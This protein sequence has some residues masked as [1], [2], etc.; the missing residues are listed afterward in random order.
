MDALPA[1]E[2]NGEVVTSVNPGV[3]HLCGHDIHMAV[4]LTAARMMSDNKDRLKFNIRFLFQPSEEMFRGGAKGMVEAGCL[5]GVERVYGL[6]NDPQIDYGKISV[7]PGIMSSNGDQFKVTIEGKSA[8]ASAPHLGRDA[9]SEAVRLLNSFRSIITDNVDPNKAALISTCMLKVGEAPNILARNAEFQGSI[10]SFDKDVH[11]TLMEKFKN[12]LG[13]TCRRGFNVELDIRGY[14]AINN[15]RQATQDLIDVGHQL[16]GEEGVLTD[17]PPM[18]GS[19]DF[20]YFLE[21]RPGAFFFLGSG[22]HAKGICNPL[23]SNP[24]IANEKSIL[25]GALIYG[26]LV[27]LTADRSELQLSQA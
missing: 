8:H 23:H 6:H 16:L 10:R 13:E 25:L 2:K 19:E 14:P 9:L 3:A 21:E 18:V 4:S 5:K 26:S 17:L 22:D 7:H 27:G 20:S 12:E 11:N 24:F 1:E 15:H